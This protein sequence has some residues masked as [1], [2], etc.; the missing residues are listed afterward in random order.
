MP[1]IVEIGY[2]P[3]TTHPHPHVN[4]SL[5]SCLPYTSLSPSIL[6]VASRALRLLA[7]RKAGGEADAKKNNV[8]FFSYSYIILL[9]MCSYYLLVFI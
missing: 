9:P 1:S 7:S 2:T 3:P 4:G 8:V 6:Y 5:G